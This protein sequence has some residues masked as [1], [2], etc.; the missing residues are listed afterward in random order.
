M[1]VVIAAGGTGGH[2]Y[3]AVALAR[4]F[5]RQDP[6]TSIVFVGTDRGIE[7]K[8]LAH[9]GLELVKI[10]ALPVMGIGLAR[11]LKGML[12]LPRSVRQS[13]DVLRARQTDLVIGI[14]GYTTPPVI[15][16]AALRRIPRVILEP[17]AYPGMANRALGPLADLVFVAFEAA[18]RHFRSARV[19]VVGTPIR[20]A[21]LEGAMLE[22]PSPGTKTLLVFGGSQ[23][24]RAINEAMMEALPKLTSFKGRIKIVHQTGEADASRVSKAYQ[25]S[26]LD[27]DVLP[28]LFDMPAVLKRADLVVSRAGAVTVAE[29]TACAKPA[30]LIPLPQAIYQ[31]QER[32]ARFMESAGAVEV[33]L[34]GE[35]TGGTLATRIEVLLNDP[36]RLATMAMCSRRL[37]RLDAA[38]VI[39]RDCHDLVKVKV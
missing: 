22:R 31:H 35:L 27:A 21:F 10:D 26:G 20:R 34:Q 18:G 19:R 6:K 8:V 17:N 37:G 14:G 15:A 30:I 39:V 11:S 12:S 24:A 9:E 36:A 1:N 4:E 2:L 7:T 23:G 13:L 3:P 29:L 28:F 5:I 33:L 16:A 25:L 32:N 38:D